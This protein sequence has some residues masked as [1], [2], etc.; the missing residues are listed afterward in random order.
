MPT[1]VYIRKERTAEH[2]NNLRL[3]NLGKKHTEE[4]KNKIRLSQIG[5]FGNLNNNFKHGLSNDKKYIKLLKQKNFAL[6]R[7]KSDLSIET[8]QLVYEDNIKKYGTLTC[9]LCELPIEFGKDELEHKI[10]L[11]RGGNN[12]YENLAIACMNCNCKKN[13]KTEKEYRNE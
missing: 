13:N 5:K 6:K 7:C 1:G 11:T 12:L 9:Y 10:P 8:I 2:K 4:T 3:V